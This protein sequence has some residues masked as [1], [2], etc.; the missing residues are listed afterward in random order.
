MIINF[1]YNINNKLQ[2]V[3]AKLKQYEEEYNRTFDDNNENGDDD[4][5]D[6][7][8][9]ETKLKQCKDEYNE[10]QD[11][12]NNSLN[13]FRMKHKFLNV[14][15]KKLKQ[16]LMNYNEFKYIKITNTNVVFSKDFKK[17]Y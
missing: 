13:E 15:D 4:V 10:K 12:Y 7:Q 11:H 8:E 14:S 16:L 5:F 2:N 3:E 1:K 9:L 6:I 17:F